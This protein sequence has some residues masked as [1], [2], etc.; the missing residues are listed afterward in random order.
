MYNHPEVD[1]IPEG[2]STQHLRTLVP[3]AIDGMVF[4]TRVLKYWVL[5]P[6]GNMIYNGS[7]NDH[8]LSSPGWL[9]LLAAGSFGSFESSGPVEPYAIRVHVLHVL[10]FG[11]HSM[12]R[13]G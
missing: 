5:G 4:G 2:P 11:P 6:S 3:K 13:L 10:G 1:R 7:F 12:D 9:Y 8:I